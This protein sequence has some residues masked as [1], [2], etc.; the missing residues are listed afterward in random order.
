MDRSHNRPSRALGW[1]ALSFVAA[2]CAPLARALVL[3]GATAVQTAAPSDDPGWANVVSPNGCSGVYLGNQWVLTAAHV[4]PNGVSSVPIAGTAYGVQP[5]TTIRLC[6]PD[7]AG[8]TDLL[9][10]RLAA[11]PGLAAVEL[12][13]GELGANTSVTLIG[14]GRTRGAVVSYDENWVLDGTPATYTGYAWSTAQKNWGT[15]RI[16]GTLADASGYGFGAVVVYA[17]DF[18]RSGDQGGTTNEAQGAQF[19]SGGGVFAKVSGRWRLAGIMV[20]I[21]PGSVP[22]GQPASTALFDNETYA[23]ELATYRPQIEAVR[24]L[25]APLDI[26]WYSRFRNTA[27]EALGDADGDGFPNFAEYAYGL[28]PQVANAA[29]AAPQVAL[30]GYADGVALTATYTRDTAAADMPVTV[31]VSEDLLNWTS[32]D[33]ATAVV[34]T[35][36]V[37]GTVSRLVVRDL[38]TTGGAA[39]RF[40]RVRVGE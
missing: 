33:T 17:T 25:V 24:A 15:N 35:A 36:P 40:M 10:F 14:Y 32:G 5:N 16:A 37:G 13:S 8:V 1:L 31:E 39:R 4:C 12:I 19:D 20:S 6:T 28:D 26:W 9:L 23:M 11:D 22:G 18:T 7:G 3:G 38:A 2:A 21:G 30:A 27:T 34:S 29:T